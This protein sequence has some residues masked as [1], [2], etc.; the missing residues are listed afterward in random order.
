MT[1]KRAIKF[2]KRVE[3][4]RDCLSTLGLGQYTIDRV[5]TTDEPGGNPNSAACVTPSAN[6]D[7]A[8]FEF[9]NDIVDDA[10]E[11]ND[12]EYLDQTI[13]HEWLHV[14]FQSQQNAIELVH[15]KLAPDVAEIWDEQL[16]HELER[17]IDRLA[18]QLYAAFYSDVVP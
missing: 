1:S 5:T 18:R 11:S 3:A 8:V 6:Y 16:T 10:Y 14:V 7:R 17:L 12:F 15:D 13:I 4:W 2:A 9:R